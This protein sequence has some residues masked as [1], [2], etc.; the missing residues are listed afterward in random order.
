[1]TILADMTRQE[2]FWWLQ[3]HGQALAIARD[4]FLEAA[5]KYARFVAK[6]E[7]A[8]E[9]TGATAESFLST[10]MDGAD[11]ALAEEVRRDLGI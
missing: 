6:C 2:A 1:M 4:E 10:I 11:G 7:G 5:T 3:E 9:R 8:L